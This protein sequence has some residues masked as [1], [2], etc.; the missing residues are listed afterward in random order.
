M[1]D[2]DSNSYV[3]ST[4]GVIGVTTDGKPFTT[5]INPYEGPIELIK[6]HLSDIENR[7]GQ[8]TVAFNNFQQRHKQDMEIK[9]MQIHQILERQGRITKG[10]KLPFSK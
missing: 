1:S 4:H 8:L 2:S 6:S 3:V 7:L 10:F 5:Q 9:D